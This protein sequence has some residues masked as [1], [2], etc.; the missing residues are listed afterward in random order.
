MQYNVRKLVSLVTYVQVR[1]DASS[2]HK[3]PN[4]PIFMKASF[5]KVAHSYN[6]NTNFGRFAY[7]TETVKLILS[8]QMNTDIP[9]FHA[10]PLKSNSKE[11]R[12]SY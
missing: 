3:K 1:F 2:F 12:L 7:I 9:T 6:D 11:I 10:L 5:S 4:N 8:D